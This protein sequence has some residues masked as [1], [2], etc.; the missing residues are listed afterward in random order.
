MTVAATT[1][2]RLE[3][4]NA[5]MN[6]IIAAPVAITAKA[7]AGP[8]VDYW[9]ERFVAE[10][11][12]YLHIFVEA[13]FFIKLDERTVIVGVVDDSVM[14][15]ERENATIVGCEW[16]TCK[17]PK[18]NKG[19]SDSAYWNEQIWLDQI[20]EGAQ[21]GTYALA[22]NRGTFLSQRL[23]T[24][25]PE[26]IQ[27]SVPEPHIRVRAL[28]KEVPTPRIWPTN[29]ENGLF[30]FSAGLLEYVQNAYRVKAAMIRAMRAARVVPWQLPGDHCRKFNSTCRYYESVC[31]PHRH[32]PAE[33]ATVGLQPGDPANKI[34]PYI[35]MDPRDPQ[36]VILSYSAYSSASRCA[37][38][39]R[40][41]TM[42]GAEGEES[43]ALDLGA[44]V[45]AGISAVNKIYQRNN[46]ERS[47]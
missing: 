30:K 13:P 44:A 34:L 17:A 10:D 3:C 41:E 9:I 8:Y 36:V 11:S 26:L 32:P 37:E 21:L 2:L 46:F 45:H 29:A 27:M 28:V 7:L 47:V 18:K 23:D 16:K 20:R 39:H 14:S 33:I 24:S 38:L 5:A 43:E 1:D 6:A 31:V 22:M 19:G 15:R 42:E 35:G 4:H 25:E 40:I 12:K